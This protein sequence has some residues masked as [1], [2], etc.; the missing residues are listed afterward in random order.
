MSTIKFQ[1]FTGQGYTYALTPAT[2]LLRLP[3][4]SGNYIFA[5]GSAADPKPI[6]VEEAARLAAPKR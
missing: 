3:E 4:Q 2:E 5:S 1:G 6:F